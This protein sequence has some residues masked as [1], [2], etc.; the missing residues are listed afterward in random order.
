MTTPFLLPRATDTKSQH[1]WAQSLVDSLRREVASIKKDATNKGSDLTAVLARLEALEKSIAELLSIFSSL[2]TEA[3]PSQLQFLAQLKSDVNAIF[4]TTQADL[5]AAL[6][7]ARRTAQSAMVHRLRS[8]GDFASLR[9]EQ[10]RQLGKTFALAQQIEALEVQIG[11]AYAGIVEE[12]TVRIDGDEALAQQITS[13]QAEVDDTIANIDIEAITR[14]IDNQVAQASLITTLQTQM[15]GQQASI[16]Q[17]F[18]SKNA[19]D[20]RWSVAI[21]NGN[22]VTGLVTLSG[23]GNVTTFGIL[24]DKFFIAQPSGAG[25]SKQVFDLITPGGGGTAQL[26]I[27]ADMYVDGTIAA[28]KLFVASLSAI[29][30]D[31][32]TVTTGRIR[33]PDGKFDMNLTGSNRYIRITS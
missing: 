21:S 19:H 27:R 4:A 31:L 16:T 24:A 20:N 6:K 14:V 2:D 7:A 13:L 26:G 17:L 9:V 11:N 8:Q 23:S 30:A 33:S 18:E 25:G 29:A 1:L 15:G 28:A 22:Y 5:D 10:K 32:G 12:R 3:L